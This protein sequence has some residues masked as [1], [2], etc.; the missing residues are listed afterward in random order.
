MSRR[1]TQSSL[2]HE[3]SRSIQLPV[4]RLLA[5][6]KDNQNSLIRHFD[7]LYI[8]QGIERLSKEVSTFNSVQKEY[9]HFAFRSLKG[10]MDE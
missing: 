8:Q 5:Q 7:L 4:A 2:T 9:C 10:K 3:D 6:F 1:E